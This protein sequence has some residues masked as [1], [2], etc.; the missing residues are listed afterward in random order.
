MR[1][2]ISGSACQGKST[3]VN[4]IL[5]KWP[6]YKRSDE[7]YRKVLKEENLKINKQVN[8]ESQWRILNCLVDD[9]LKTSKNDNVIFDRCPLD[10]LIYSVWSEDK[11]TSDID[12]AFIDK[13]I[14]LVQE[15]MRSIDIIFFLPITKVAPVEIKIKE[16]REIDAAFIQEIDHIFKAIT[17]NLMIHGQC[18]FMAKDDRP[19][20]IEIFGN[21]EQR[22]EM[23]KLYLT[24]SGDLIDDQSSVLSP[25]NI[26]QMEAV[27][28]AQ[29][30]ALFEEK[31]E[32][33]VRNKI[34]G[35]L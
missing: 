22:V 2:A 5:K 26:G 33:R 9:I 27:L 24:E 12:K 35:G 3:L 31:Q 17:Y 23:L 8:K 20:I 16:D 28:K 15:S 7:S 18:P 34:I 25:E 1:L 29:K 21:P 11:Q 10:N 19:P 13:C 14:P 30:K 32:T 6:S 4:D